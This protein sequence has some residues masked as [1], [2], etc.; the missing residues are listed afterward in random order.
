MADHGTSSTN[1]LASVD[2]EENCQTN[3]LDNREMARGS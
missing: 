2:L 3:M 1:A